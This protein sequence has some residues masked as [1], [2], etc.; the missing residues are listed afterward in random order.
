MQKNIKYYGNL[1]LYLMN[2]EFNSISENKN[3]QLKIK[4]FW[5]ALSTHKGEDIFV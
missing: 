5:C 2:N 4:N 3:N 1:K